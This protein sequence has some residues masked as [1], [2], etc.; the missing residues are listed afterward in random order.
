MGQH[1][2]IEIVEESGK[3]MT[4]KEIKDAYLKKH[5]QIVGTILASL[6]KIRRFDL[7]NYKPV[8]GEH[9]KPDYKY[10]VIR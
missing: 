4:T 10:W 3:V 8:K 7:L 1:E 5:G 6:R 9:G 2:I